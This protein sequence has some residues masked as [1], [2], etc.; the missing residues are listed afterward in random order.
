M[1]VGFAKL[2][3]RK[4]LLGI[5]GVCLLLASALFQPVKA[6]EQNAPFQQDF[7][8][9]YVRPFVDGDRQELDTL[10]HFPLEGD[11][12]YIMKLEKDPPEW[13]KEDFYSNYS[14]LFNERI[15]EIILKK[16]YDEVHIHDWK[17]GPQEVVYSIGWH[18]YGFESQILLRYRKVD[19][20]WLLTQIQGAG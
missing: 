18:D 12:G 16:G 14:L 11:W 8:E 17:N 4:A 19:H 5:T 9:K 6:Q 20:K 10:I 15:K 13:N 2:I 3:S 7:W 1:G